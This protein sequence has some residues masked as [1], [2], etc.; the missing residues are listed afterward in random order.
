[1]NCREQCRV[2]WRIR[3]ADG[4]TARKHPKIQWKKKKVPEDTPR[5]RTRRKFGAEASADADALI[6][7]RAHWGHSR[8]KVE[9]AGR[10]DC[11]HAGSYQKVERYLKISFHSGKRADGR[12]TVQHCW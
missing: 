12:T 3:S 5:G 11:Q 7:Q 8:K 6:E 1:M 4:Q 10:N 2:E 9:L